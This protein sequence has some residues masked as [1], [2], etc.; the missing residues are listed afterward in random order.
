MRPRLEARPLE[1]HSL[2]VSYPQSEERSPEDFTAHSSWEVQLTD[3]MWKRE[4]DHRLKGL[5]CEGGLSRTH[6]RQL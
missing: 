3:E 5:P 1:P 6:D 2:S 4:Q